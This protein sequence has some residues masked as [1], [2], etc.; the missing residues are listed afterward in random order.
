MNPTSSHI[1][2]IPIWQSV[3]WFGIP[4]LIGYVGLYYGVPYL[5]NLGFPL[6]FSFP[7]F[8]WLPIAPM[9][10][11]SLLMF[12]RERRQHNMLFAERF[13]FR[14]PTPRDWVYM[15]GGIIAVLF[16]DFVVGENL[17]ISEWLATVPGFRPPDHFPVLFHPLK[18]IHLPLATFL[19]VPL[20]GNWLLLIMAV[21]LHVYMLMSEEFLW[22]G[23]L[24]PRHIA[25]HGKFAWLVNGLL[26]AYLLHAMLKWHFISF[27]PGMLITPWC[28]QKTQNTWVSC[29]VHIIPNSL[30][31]VLLLHGIMQA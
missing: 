26:W 21:S 7:F 15:L 9:L 25:T 16:F 11:I 13:R 22:R 18:E 31:W 20:K 23:Y 4:G 2:P 14:K 19:D 29:A 12:V 30:L 24:L 28:A 1:Q 6:I 8:L 27:L 10:P 5:S 17:S 3:L